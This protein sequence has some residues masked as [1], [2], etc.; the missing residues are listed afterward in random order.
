MTLTTPQD[1]NKPLNMTTTAEKSLNKHEL[2]RPDGFT[3]ALKSFF[4]GIA[5]NSR[6]VF[7]IVGALVVIGLIAGLISSKKSDQEA[8]ARDALFKA[9]LILEKELQAAVPPPVTPATP[10][11]LKGKEAEKAA[12]AARKAEE[13]AA[14]AAAAALSKVDPDTQLKGGVAALAEVAKTYPK[15]RAGYEASIALGDLYVRHQKPALARP[16]LEAAVSSAPNKLE[17]GIA[18]YSLGVALENA[19]QAADALKA[20]DQAVSLAGSLLKADIQL[21]QARTQEATGAKD[22][23]KA[24]YDQVISGSPGTPQARTAELLKGQ[25]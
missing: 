24:T 23:A 25:L 7:S 6:A 9:E 17:K 16:Y 21:A 4:G 2:R 5:K 10:K 8:S 15:S 13:A 19:G 18:L 22:K 12:E 20:Y 1:F 14:D 3:S 11:D